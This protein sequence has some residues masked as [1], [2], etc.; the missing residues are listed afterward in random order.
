MSKANR[1]RMYEQ[2]LA[3]GKLCNDDGG[4]VKEF[5]PKEIPKPIETPKPKRSKR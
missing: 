2:C 5:G 4:L 1:K 3:N